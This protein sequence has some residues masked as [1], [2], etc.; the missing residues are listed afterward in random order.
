LLATGEIPEKVRR[1]AIASVEDIR[2]DAVLL[3]DPAD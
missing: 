1:I 2:E 3:R